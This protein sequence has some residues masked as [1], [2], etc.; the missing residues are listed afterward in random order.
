M[1]GLADFVLDPLDISGRQ[2]GEV[3]LEA[4]ELQAASALFEEGHPLR[5]RALLEL[6]HA[7]LRN[8]ERDRAVDAA[9]SAL[10]ESKEGGLRRASKQLLDSIVSRTAAQTPPKNP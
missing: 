3:A 1:S 6:S 4:S 7:L 2:A 5:S 8:H 10:G 9:R